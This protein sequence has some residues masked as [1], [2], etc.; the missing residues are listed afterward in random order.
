MSIATDASTP[1]PS[2]TS[3]RL[4]PALA[5]RLAVVRDRVGFTLGALAGRLRVVLDLPSRADLAATNARLD[6]I[7][8]QLAARGRRRGRGVDEA[9]SAAAVAPDRS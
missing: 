2:P 3:S 5:T 4:P 7:E 6:A 8:A 1:T 9:T